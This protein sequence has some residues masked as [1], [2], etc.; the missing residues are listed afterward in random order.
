[1]LNRVICARPPWLPGSDA[2]GGLAVTRV[3][4]QGTG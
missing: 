1:M 2:S 3:V 4:W